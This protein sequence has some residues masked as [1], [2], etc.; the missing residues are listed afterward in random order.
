MKPNDIVMKYI[1]LSLATIL[2]LGASAQTTVTLTVDMSNET[3]SADGVHVAGSFQG[4]DP[5]AT[6][7]TDNGDGTWSHM[8][9]SDSAASYQYKFINGNAWGSEEGIPD[10]CAV[11]GNRQITVDGMMGEASSTACFKSCAACGMTTVLFRVDMSNEEVSD[12]GVHIAGDFQGWEPGSTELTDPDDDMIYE[13]THSFESEVDSALFK[14][15]NGNSWFDA[16]FPEG[17]CAD[18]NANRVL[19]FGNDANIVLSANGVGD[20][21]CYNTCSSCILPLQ[22]TFT[23]DMSLVSSVS[24]QGVYIAGSF[25]GWDAESTMLADNGDGTWSTTLEVAPGAHQ[26]KFINGVGWNGGEE[27]MNGTACNEGGNR[28][29]VF[30]ANNSTYSACFNLCPEDACLP[31]PDPA[32]IT[33]QVDASEVDMMGQSM[34]VFGAFTGWQGGAIAMTNNGDGIW[35]TTQLVSGSVNVDYKY[36]IGVPN[37]QGNDESGTYVLAGDSTTFETAGCGVSNGFSGFN[38]RFVRSGMD[39]VIPLHCYNSCGVCVTVLG[40]TDLHAVNYNS[41]ANEDDG[42]CEYWS[43]GCDECQANFDFGD[44]P[45]GFSPD[46]TLGQSFT[47]G[48]LGLP[49]ADAWHILIP[50][51]GAGIDSAYPPQLAVDS[52]IVMADMING[53]GEYSG[54]VFMDTTTMEL[55]HAD[56]L[57]LSFVLN[58][59]GDSPN[60]T[61]MLGGGQYCALLSGTPT[62]EGVYRIAIGTEAW[63]TIA[64]PFSIPY[65]YDNFMLTIDSSGGGCTDPTACNYNT[66]AL[67]DDGFCLY[68]GDPCDDCNPGTTI[69][70]L[71]TN[72]QCVGGDGVTQGCTDP[73]AN[74]YNPEAGSDDGTCEYDVLGCTDPGA[75][76]Y[77]TASN[78]ND[79][80]CEYDC[81]LE[82]VQPT[83]LFFSEY[84]EGWANNKALEIFNPTSDLIDLSDYQI[85]RYSNGAT[86][87]AANQRVTLSGFLAPQDVVVCVLDKRDP[88]GVD[89]ETPVL[90][91]LAEKA[92]L[93]LCPIYDENNAM[94]F[95]GND[96]LVLRKISTNTVI[97]VFGSVGED[98]GTEGWAS[99]TQNHTLV[100]KAFVTQGGQNAV[101]NF[102]VVDEWSSIPWVGDGLTDNLDVVFENLGA[103]GYCFGTNGTVGGCTDPS[104]FNFDPTA[105]VDDGSCVYFE[106]SCA[107]IG[108]PE[109]EA[110]ELGL[111]APTALVHT[112]GQSMSQEVVLHVPSSIE[113]PGSGTTYAVADWSGLEVSGMPSGL[114]FDNLPGAISGGSQICLTYSGLPTA[115]GTYEVTL[116]GELFLSVFGNPVSAGV[117]AASLVITI[118]ANGNAVLGCTYAHALNFNPVANDDDGS[119]AFAGCTD[120]GAE[121]FEPH[122]S[123][124]DGTCE[125]EPCVASCLGDL[126]NDGTIG[127]GDL[128]ALLTTFGGDCE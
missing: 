25:Q 120:P 83:G 48:N 50:T 27:N 63:A 107:A 128:L 101:D 39:V 13:Y 85:E 29:A 91:A 16:E 126:N 77:D 1:F 95:N 30:D 97:D 98:P 106:T 53:A 19:Q 17:D 59:G 88:D 28:G 124:D 71:S 4:W 23:V 45:F 34:F 115:A 73:Q 47:E 125:T 87:S 117:Y 57:G 65:V 32:N 109:W 41:E 15:I 51:T 68:P 104:A 22:V 118:E 20:A 110:F 82:L 2:S 60:H 6:P 79:G 62:R 56:D 78:N 74:N 67:V 40:C 93:W 72:C 42:T 105:D 9:T 75:S 35:Q 54:V 114:A 24:D 11:D 108:A 5:S 84:V 112:T 58:N 70:L 103:H 8:F 46:P 122:A 92:D 127:S 38:R 119:C 96:A 123:V 33:F 61:T 80:S 12:F 86:S 121:N 21:Y 102:P 26:F 89:F 111:Y 55:F 14:F 81:S 64:A 37:D 94:Y 66:N 7:M 116:T 18:V 76:N 3:V 100:R 52:V 31:D 49:Y 43:P 113:E 99:L 90:E 36:S 10:A 44:A 69:D